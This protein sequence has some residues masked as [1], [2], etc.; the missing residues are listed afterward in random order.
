MCDSEQLCVIV[1][2]LKGIKEVPC[3]FTDEQSKTANS[4]IYQSWHIFK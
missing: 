1:G 2:K 3:P 4:S